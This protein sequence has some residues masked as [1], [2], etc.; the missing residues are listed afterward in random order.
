MDQRLQG[1]TF[2]R[3]GGGKFGVT[4]EQSRE[5]MML[6]GETGQFQTAFFGALRQARPLDMRCQVAMADA[7]Q[8]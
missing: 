4:R 3:G 5:E 7:F 8:G 1:A 6:I 2:F